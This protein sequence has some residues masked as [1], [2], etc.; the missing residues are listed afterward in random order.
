MAERD[1]HV[2]SAIAGRIAECFF[3]IQGEGVTA[4]L[5]AIFIRLQGCSVGCHWCDTKYSWDPAEGR[6]QTLEALLEEVA[7]FP[8]SRV[9][10]T[11]GEPLESPL[12][13]PLVEVLKTRH[14]AVEVETS[15]TLPPPSV[16]V[17]QWN[18][19]LKLANSRVPEATRINPKAIRDFLDRDAWWK[20]VVADRGDIG[21]VR[22]LM[23]RFTLPRDRILLMPEGI[24]AAEI[25]ERSTWVVEECRHHGFRYSPRLHV[26]LW[27]AKRGV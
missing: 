24:H 3:S 1:S 9:V 27:G 11:G 10:V 26:L 13:A 5:P 17:D 12:F 8:C 6:E 23:Q 21:E 4:G 14:Y 15:G 20:F 7:T 22:Q 2:M 18:V 16:P 19:S 25:L